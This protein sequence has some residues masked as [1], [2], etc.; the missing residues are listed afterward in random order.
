[1]EFKDRLVY[2]RKEMH[3]TQE[4][5]SEKLGISRTALSAWEIGRNEPSNADTIR[6]AIFFN[7]SVD[8]LLGKSD[9]REQLT[10]NLSND[11][12]NFIKN[13]KKLDETNKMIIRNTME[14][15]L[16]KQEK[17]NKQC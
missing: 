1:M 11:E 4:E 15:L 17:D 16:D 9:I 7:V 8:Y 12:I 5:L 14:A 13:I 3:L 10:F 6:L 2:L